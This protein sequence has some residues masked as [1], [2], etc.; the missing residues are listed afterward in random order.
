MQHPG[1]IL[2]VGRR[3]GSL[4][5]VVLLLQ[6]RCR[7][8]AAGIMK[9]TCLQVQQQQKGWVGASRDELQQE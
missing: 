9:H 4:A 3:P 2:A 5:E 7:A 6:A 1:G 8:A